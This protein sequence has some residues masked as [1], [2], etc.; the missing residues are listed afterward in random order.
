MRETISLLLLF[1]LLSS[2]LSSSST[3][4]FRD[5]LSDL[6]QQSTQHCSNLKSTD[7]FLCE[8]TGAIDAQGPRSPSAPPLLNS[9]CKFKEDCVYST[10][11]P[12]ATPPSP[13]L[14]TILDKYVAMRERCLAKDSDTLLDTFHS[15]ERPNCQYVI[16]RQTNAGFG[17]RI[18][19]LISTFLYSIFSARVLLVDYPNWN[20]LF[21]EPFARS[22]LRVPQ[23]YPLDYSLGA[24]YLQYLDAKCGSPR[25]NAGSSPCNQTIVHLIL[26]HASPIREYDSVLCPLGYSRL[27]NIPFVMIRDSNQY[28]VPGYYANPVLRPLMDL[29]FPER[30]IFHVLSRFLLFPSDAMWGSIRLYLD[31]HA[32]RRV[33]LQIREFKIGKYTTEYDDNI[34]RCLRERGGL[35]PKRFRKRVCEDEYLA[36]HV[37]TLEKG[38]VGRMNETMKI[39]EEETGKEVRVKWQEVESR[40]LHDLTQQKEAL[41]D[42]WVLSTSHVLIT[43]MESTF[44]YVANGLSGVPSYFIDKEE[45]ESCK[46]N[47]G[48]DLCFHQAPKMLVCSDDEPVRYRAYDLSV[49]SSWIRPCVDRLVFGWSL[50]GEVSYPL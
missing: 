50:A 39:I 12:Y 34:V 35:L 6:S 27:R 43:S 18:I 5:S 4:E 46:V 33:G 49:N 29:L 32:S 7:K 3:L 45:S 10:Y 9:T 23:G 20:D 2:P 26:D 25:G 17:N 24:S 38:H 37:A 1:L 19:S 36:I 42:M 13:E 16:W 21:C 8:L 22:S 40:E 15:S 48:V 47:H 31:V 11:Y 28:F 14:E 30:N 41:I 44:G